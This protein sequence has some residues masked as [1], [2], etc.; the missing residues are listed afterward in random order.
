MFNPVKPQV[1][2]Q[3]HNKCLSWE[4]RAVAAVRTYYSENQTKHKSALR[5]QNVKILNVEASKEYCN[6]SG[7]TL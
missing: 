3:L 2:Q 6:H 1:H 5:L 7:L 4:D